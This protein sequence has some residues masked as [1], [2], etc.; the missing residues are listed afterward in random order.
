MLPLYITRGGLS[1]KPYCL[2][3]S[4]RRDLSYCV[5]ENFHVP[6]LPGKGV[7]FKVIASERSVYVFFVRCHAERKGVSKKGLEA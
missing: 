4:P 5:V 2:A 7:T 3:T 6:L 1:H